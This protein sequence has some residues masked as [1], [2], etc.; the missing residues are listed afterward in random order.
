V[1]RRFYAIQISLLLVT[2]ASREAWADDSA[3]PAEK[4]VAS[5][6]K[7]DASKK[8]AAN[9]DATKKDEADGEHDP[10]SV[11]LHVA[12]SSPIRVVR[13]DTGETVCAAPC[14]QNVPANGRYRIDG[15]RPSPA[16]SLAPGAEGRADVKVA[17]GSKGEFWV[18]IGIMGLGAGLLTGGIYT[19]LYWTANKPA[20]P[21]GDGVDTDNRYDYAMM[22]GTGLVLLGTIAEIY[23]GAT[24]I[25]NLR[26]KV[27]G[28]V[29]QAKAS[30]L[31]AR[32]AQV[33]AV[34]LPR[35]SS[36]PIFGGTF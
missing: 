27:K 20:V 30:D 32:P 26:T 8:D 19:L 24:V 21:G 2:V 35:P 29:Q 10:N 1:S 6:A 31:P 23:G 33:G 16:F 36:V 34:S 9:K 14:D 5:D 4:P 11:F 22:A 13:D 3:K 18:G 28:N 25:N 17:P 7:T 15:A 12:T